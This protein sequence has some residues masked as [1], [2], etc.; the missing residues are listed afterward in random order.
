MT[1]DGC[2]HTPLDEKA[3]LASVARLVADGVTSLALVFLHS[4][5][6]SPR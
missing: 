5:R 4:P 6:Q 2:V 1:V 3:L